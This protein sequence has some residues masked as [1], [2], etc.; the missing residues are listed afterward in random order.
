MCLSAV[1]CARTAEPI[2]MPFGFWNRVGPRKHLL[3]GGAHWRHLANTIE[4]N[5]CGG[6]CGL[7]SNCI[8]HLSLFRK[9]AGDVLSACLCSRT[10]E[11]SVTA[12]TVFRRR[13]QP[14]KIPFPASAT[15]ER[16]RMTSAVRHRVTWTRPRPPLP[17]T[18]RGVMMSK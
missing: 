10:D 6:R 3:G 9:Q 14:T 13:G 7:L 15:A 1:S 12:T 4:P 2:E 18:A 17:V 11:E 16:L 8:N 5:M